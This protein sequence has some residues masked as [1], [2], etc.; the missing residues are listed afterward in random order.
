VAAGARL[1]PVPVDE[2]GIVVA[3]GVLRA[4][5]ARLAVVSPSHQY[6]SGATLSLTR[7]AA[8]LAW[9]RQA[10]AWIV[11]DDYDSYF[12]Y[13]G[14]PCSALQPLDALSSP[15]QRYCIQ[16]PAE[17]ALVLGYGGL[18]PQRIARGVERLARALDRAGAS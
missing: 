14:R 2:Q 11:E 7:R 12:R 5:D 6:P 10:G 17:E 4:P 15:Q 18:S 1:A 9:A 3:E 8:L 13:R 16:P